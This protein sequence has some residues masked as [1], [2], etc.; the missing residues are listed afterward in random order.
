MRVNIFAL[1]W[2]CVAFVH[3]T[4]A[5]RLVQPLS[6]ISSISEF[7]LIVYFFVINVLLNE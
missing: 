5:S 2:R 1:R 7:K 4:A 6:R 3:Q